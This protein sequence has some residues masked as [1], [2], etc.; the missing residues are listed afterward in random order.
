MTGSKDGRIPIAEVRPR[1]PGNYLVVMERT[2]QMITLEAPKFNEYLAEEGLNSI[3]QKRAAIGATAN[4]GRERYTRYLKALLQVGARRDDTYMR[5]AG[6]RLEIIP[7]NNP[8]D[9]RPGGTLRIRVLFEGRPLPGA[10]I[11][12]YNRLATAERAHILSTNLSAEGYASFTLDRA[13]L[14]LVR[15]VHMRSCQKCLDADW[16]S[17]WAAYAFELR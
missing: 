5:I 3:L 4:E 10:R 6:Q 14:W 12:A 8:Y 7:E 11:F 1:T 17:F 2:P 9:L 16:E 13:G 15:L